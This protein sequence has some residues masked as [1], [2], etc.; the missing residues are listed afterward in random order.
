MSPKK[1]E[2]K[3]KLTYVKMSLYSIRFL[4]YVKCQN[5]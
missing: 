5:D 2:K 3:K 4:N 1:S